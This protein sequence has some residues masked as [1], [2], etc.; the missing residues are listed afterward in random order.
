MQIAQKIIQ[1][2]ELVNIDVNAN[3]TNTRFYFPDQPQ[4]RGRK[5]WQITAYN[6]TQMFV[7]PDNVNLA[8]IDDIK[9]AFLILVN[10]IGREVVRVPLVSLVNI[11]YNSVNNSALLINHNANMPLDDITIVWEKSYIQL[12]TAAITQT[13]FTYQFGVFYK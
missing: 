5:I 3:E 10:S 12:A 7:S 11:V 2:Y 4:L 8:G 9:N 6:N 1:R 13:A